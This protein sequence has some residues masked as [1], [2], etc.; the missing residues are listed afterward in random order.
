MSLSGLFANGMGLST[1]G[2][3]IAIYVYILSFEIVALLLRNMG[4]GSGVKSLP[5]RGHI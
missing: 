5:S 4:G 2:E 3:E 1:F